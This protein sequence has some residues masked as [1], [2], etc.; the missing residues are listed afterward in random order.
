MDDW[1][2]YWHFI[3]MFYFQRSDTFSSMCCWFIRCILRFSLSSSEIM[4]A[5][6]HANTTPS[7]SI[8]AKMV[9]APAKTIKIMATWFWKWKCNTTVWKIRKFTHTFL[10][11]ILRE[12]KP[13]S[14]YYNVSC[15]SCFH[16]IFCKWLHN[17]WK[18]LLFI[19]FW[20]KK[21]LLSRKSIL[22]QLSSLVITKYCIQLTFSTCSIACKHPW[23]CIFW[24]LF[25]WEKS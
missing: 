19:S 22:Y 23:T 6:Q 1:N 15:V 2:D 24:K 16:E 8:I 10:L 14:L 20:R 25:F 21:E 5:K 11:Q 13:L 9:P 17:N 7:N 4:F 12:I 18:T 3:F